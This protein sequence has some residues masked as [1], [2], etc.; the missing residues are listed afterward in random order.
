ME[1]L[2]TTD[3]FELPDGSP[4]EQP[5]T[6]SKYF[7][8]P[9][10]GDAWVTSAGRAR[11]TSATYTYTW[12]DTSTE[13]GTVSVKVAQ[14]GSGAWLL[15]RFDEL[16]NTYFRFGQNNGTYT[17]QFM[18]HENPAGM[19]VSVET[20][21]S[22]APQPGDLLKVQQHPDGTVEC[23]VNGVITH[24]FVDNVTNFR[25][26]LNGIGADGTGAALDDF[27]VVP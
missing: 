21:A 18:H 1:G 20:L 16:T 10:L 26:T 13:Q 25:W 27:Q 6:G 22:P 4:L 9:W 19:P 2:I 3:S 17:V 24:R 5:T 15:F 12:V 14:H 11:P 23:S 7:W 8:R